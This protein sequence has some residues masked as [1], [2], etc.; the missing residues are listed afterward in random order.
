MRADRRLGGPI[1]SD[2][3]D[4]AAQDSKDDLDFRRLLQDL[5]SMSMLSMSMTDAD[6]LV[7]GGLG[8][9]SSKSCGGKSGKSSSLSMSSSISMSISSKSSKSKSSKCTTELP[10]SPTTTAAPDTVSVA[11]YASTF[12]CRK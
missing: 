3:S 11:P 10:V 2:V 1:S 4:V 7:D 12:H 8:T 5:Q 9:K 6:K